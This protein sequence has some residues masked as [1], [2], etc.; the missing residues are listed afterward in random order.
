LSWDGTAGRAGSQ[1]AL[2]HD[3]QT[4]TT[5]NNRECQILINGDYRNVGI[6]RLLHQKKWFDTREIVADRPNLFYVLPGQPREPFD[7]T[8][9]RRRFG[10][11]FLL[12][13]F[14]HSSFF[15]RGKRVRASHAFA[16]PWCGRV[17]N[18][19]APVK[20]FPTI[21]EVEKADKEQLARWY[22]F[23]PSGE[24]AADQKIMKRI[25][26]RFERL[27]GMT[28]ALSKKIGM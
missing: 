11:A 8:T 10:Q 9:G 27:G 18:S 28:P 4:S 5:G 24:S 22:R 1:L 14:R 19:C 17:A 23:L 21:Q 15:K 12:S 3:K 16:Y 2:N 20:G 13:S 26:E 25:A 6:R 7:T